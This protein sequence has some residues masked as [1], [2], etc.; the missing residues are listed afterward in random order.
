MEKSRERGNFCIDLENKEKSKRAVQFSDILKFRLYLICIKLSRVSR[1]CVSFQS[2]QNAFARAYL[3][4]T[5]GKSL[6]IF[7]QRKFDECLK[8]LLKYV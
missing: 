7:L 1:Q 6:G 4:I 8:L 5:L 3:A 2:C